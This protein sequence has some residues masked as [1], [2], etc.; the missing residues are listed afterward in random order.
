MSALFGNLFM[1]QI[2]YLTLCVFLVFGCYAKCLNFRFVNKLKNVSRVYISSLFRSPFVF[3]PFLF[4]V[5]HEHWSICNVSID[6]GF[7]PWQVIQYDI[8]SNKAV[9]PSGA[10]YVKGHD[11]NDRLIADFLYETHIQFIKNKTTSYSLI[12]ELYMS[13]T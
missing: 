12:F 1:P 11:D 13:L 5:S 9:T 10:R 2:L 4:P 3:L 6:V 7:Q 8:L